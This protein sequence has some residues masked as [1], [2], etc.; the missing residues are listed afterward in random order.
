MG[1]APHVGKWETGSKREFWL[2]V[3]NANSDND[4]ECQKM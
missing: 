1:I 2:I 3:G 4:N